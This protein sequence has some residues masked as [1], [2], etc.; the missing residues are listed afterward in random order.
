MEAALTA[1]AMQALGYGLAPNVGA[2]GT[3]MAMGL[4]S[5]AATQLGGMALKGIG[6]VLSGNG[7]IRRKRKAEQQETGTKGCSCSEKP[8]KPKY[9]CE[10]KCAYGRYMAEKCK[11]CTKYSRKKYY[12]YKPRYS[13]GSRCYSSPSS[14]R[15][16]SPSSIPYGGKKPRVSGRQYRRTTRTAAR[17]YRRTQRQAS[18]QDRRARN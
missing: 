1:G 8:T 7:P 3:E 5:M 4:G 15:Y 9:T 12:S 10:E 6:N 2:L 16:S 14:T 17:Q 11:G 18:R 13:Y